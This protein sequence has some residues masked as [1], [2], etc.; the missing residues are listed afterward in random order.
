MLCCILSANKVFWKVHYPRLSDQVIQL[1]P[2]RDRTQKG[3]WYT[4]V[5]F[6]PYYRECLLLTATLMDGWLPHFIVIVNN[7]HRDLIGRFLFL[8]IYFYKQVADSPEF[9][10]AGIVESTKLSDTEMVNIYEQKHWSGH[11]QYEQMLSIVRY[12][13]DHYSILFLYTRLG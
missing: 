6:L 10:S 9:S 1:T 3:I 12:F 2:T 13:C 4:S 7:N 11:R 5:L 8:S